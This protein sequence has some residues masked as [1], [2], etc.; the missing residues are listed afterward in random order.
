M[1][2]IAPFLFLAL[3]SPKTLWA[4]D[5]FVNPADPACSL[6]STPQ[7]FTTIQ[8]AIEFA[9]TAITGPTPTTA[10]YAVIVEPGTYPETITLRNNIPI[11][12]RETART[13]LTGGGSGTIIT[14]TNITTDTR[15]ANFTFVNAP[16]GISISNN[17]I[18]SVTNNIFRMG[19]A[20]TA[21]Q[22]TGAASAAVINNT[23]FQNA[24]AISSNADIAITNNIFSSN[25]TAALSPVI[26]VTAFTRVV[27]NC[28][29]N[30]VADGFGFLPSD[31][32]TA[33]NIPNQLKPNSDPGFVDPDSVLPDMDLHLEQSSDTPCIDQGTDVNG[34]D[35]A[36]NS[37][38]DIGAYGGPNADTIPFPVAG[39]DFS[40]DITQ[41]Q[42]VN[43]PTFTVGVSWAQNLSYLVTNTDTT[44]AG[45]YYLH[46][47]A[48]RP[49]PPYDKKDF[50]GDAPQSFLSL[51]STTATLSAP[52]LSDPGYANQ[53]LKLSWSA[54]DGATG[55]KVHYTDQGA[56]DGSEPAQQTGE[57]TIDAK[58]TTT[59]DLT[60]LINKHS[61]RVEVS[62]YG[63]TVYYVA[64]TAFNNGSPVDGRIPGVQH[65]S[66]YSPGIQ[67]PIG[68][69]APGPRSIFKEEY[70]EELTIV[71]HL[72]NTRRGCFIATA[73]Y[74]QDMARE[75]QAL[76]A[77]RD[78]FLI[79]NRPGRAFVAWYYRHGP[80]A[81]AWLN[82]HPGYK[83]LV[84]A[85]LLPAVGAARF[86]TQ[87]SLFFKFGLA[88][89][90]AFACV[91]MYLRKQQAGSGG[92]H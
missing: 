4:V 64:V 43:P 16:I 52:V 36:D 35:S 23:F 89:L 26:P 39:L 60:G 34:R 29:H 49:G 84:R 31:P 68:E 63:Q 8:S 66:A 83:P 20:G 69:I 32:N 46:Y 3:L 61:Y 76:R 22:I 81:A 28:F 27:T 37:R 30:N 78:E 14:A 11:R 90:M 24:I 54:V 73:A 72:S 70:P 48:G 50:I 38:S 47:N 80:E 6:N 82:A 58:N 91:L 77:F 13:V 41:E 40:P 92:P 19:T 86:M 79:T 33:G 1:V 75:V 65:E 67:I 44:K 12:G 2:F 85:A 10:S 59:F 18:V 5:L 21:V 53:T 87:T 55:Y 25:A 45:G 9:N 42:G 51:T 71:P 56:Y 88:M 15:V 57:Q 7:C 74:G 62:S 17:S